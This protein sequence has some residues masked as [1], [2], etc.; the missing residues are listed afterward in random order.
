[1]FHTPGCKLWKWESCHKTA[2]LWS[3]LVLRVQHQMSSFSFPKVE[4]ISVEAMSSEPVI[5]VTLEC[6]P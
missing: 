5:G 6:G 3:G 1:M 2:Q 4:D